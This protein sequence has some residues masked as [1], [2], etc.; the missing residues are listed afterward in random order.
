[1]SVLTTEDSKAASGAASGVLYLTNKKV[2]FSHTDSAGIVFYPRYFEIIN[3]VIEDWFADE[4]GVPFGELL[5][6]RRGVPTVNIEADFIS[7][8]RLDDQLRCVLSILKLGRSSFQ[9]QIE[10][11]EDDELR[12]RVR[13]T[14]VLIDLDSGKPMALPPEM[15]EAMA[16]FVDGEK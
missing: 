5:A 1:M 14:L 12:F 6:Q 3:S 7:P 11:D 16:R 10:A 4:I 2:R 9:V 15:R 13:H 8:S